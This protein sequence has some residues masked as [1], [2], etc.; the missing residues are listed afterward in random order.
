[1]VNLESLIYLRNKEKK[2]RGVLHMISKAQASV[3]YG[4]RN[5][6]SAGHLAK[7]AAGVAF[8]IKG[9]RK[10]VWR[11]ISFDMLSEVARD[12][13]AQD[14][15]NKKVEVSRGRERWEMSLY[16]WNWIAAAQ[17]K[18]ESLGEKFKADEPFIHRLEQ[19]RIGS[20]S[21]AMDPHLYAKG[22]EKSRRTELFWNVSAKDLRSNTINTL[23]YVMWQETDRLAA[24]EA[25]EFLSSS[26]RQLPAQWTNGSSYRRVGD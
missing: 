26:Q 19:S 17:E 5:D 25:H 11:Y 18:V 12:S 24:A 8:L 3:A 21:E 20:I 23:E 2:S 4:F 9:K 22:Q 6:G 16:T 10:N 13:V 14:I 7:E 15:G 1:M